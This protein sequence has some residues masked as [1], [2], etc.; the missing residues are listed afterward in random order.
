MVIGVGFAVAAVARVVSVV[1]D[2]STEP[3]NLAG[4][5]FEAVI[6][7]LLLI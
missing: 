2:R 4:I 6:A 1:V 7:W 5:A 3:Y